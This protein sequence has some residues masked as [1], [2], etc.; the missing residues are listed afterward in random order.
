MQ[1]RG[2]HRSIYRGA[3]GRALASVGFRFVRTDWNI[4]LPCRSQKSSE[5]VNRLHPKH[6]IDVSPVHTAPFE[7]A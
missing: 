4:R 5:A 2:L 7:L 6:R 1:I 3:R